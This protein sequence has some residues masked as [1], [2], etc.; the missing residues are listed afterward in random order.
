MEPD[1][2]ATAA[3]HLLERARLSAGEVR[4]RLGKALSPDYWRELVPSLS[5]GGKQPPAHMQ[6]AA[7]DEARERQAL[8]DLADRG[9][10]VT[11]PLFDGAVVRRMR[12]GVGA[13]RGAGWPAVFTFVY[14]EFWQAFQ[15]PALVR[16]LSGALGA[17]Y[18][19]VPHVWTFFI[20][21]LKGASGWPPHIDGRDFAYNSDRMTL[22]IPLG[23]ATLANG[24]MYV[25]SREGLAEPLAKNFSALDAFGAADVRSLLRGVRALPARAGSVLGWDF[26]VVHW[27]AT[28]ESGDDPRVSISTEFLRENA[29][30]ARGEQPLLGAAGAPEYR[31]RLSVIGRAILA[32]ERFE[33]PMI[34]YAELA[35]Q[36]AGRPLKEGAVP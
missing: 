9:Y 25:V 32:Y 23:D 22:W 6:A 35:R 2:V 5:V 17:G 20:P 3:R 8:R 21:P 1:T 15:V 11:E 14:D 27:G 4:D 18:R 34:R 26:G 12:E 10:F 13:V 7:T 31:E 19:Q 33:A 30:P 36:L 28:C 29:E 24:C 16:L